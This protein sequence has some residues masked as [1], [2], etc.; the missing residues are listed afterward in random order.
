V[1]KLLASELPEVARARHHW[2]VLFDLPRL[3]QVIVAAV[4][5]AALWFLTSSWIVAFTIIFVLVALIRIQTWQQE[6]V[7][8][9]QRR[10]ILTTGVPET[11]TSEA[12]L[13]VDRIHGAVFEQNAL[14]RVL[15]YGSIII[16]SPGAHRNLQKIHKIAGPVA[17]YALL[18]PM[19][20]GDGPIDDPDYRPTSHDTAD[21][22]VLRPHLH[23]LR[24]RAPGLLNKARELPARIFGP[25]REED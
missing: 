3:W 12:S 6:I 24:D 23:S 14:G 19:I 8:L 4:A 22:P 20:F 9:T 7:I 5:F 13:R 10:L 21:L 18:R 2:I 16:E 15:G 11:S 17:F 25:P 1:P